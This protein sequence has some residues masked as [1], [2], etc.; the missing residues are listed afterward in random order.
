MSSPTTDTVQV[1]RSTAAFD[2]NMPEV[3]HL[4]GGEIV[5][6]RGARTLEVTDPA[7]GTPLTTIPLGTR[8]DV[9][10][11]VSAAHNAAPS[12][13][14]LIPRARSEHLHALADA[15]ERDAD[16]LRM[17]EALNCGKPAEVTQDD[18]GS[19]VDTLRFMAGAG[20]STITPAA[21]DYVPGTLSMII[22]EPL[23]VVGLITPWNYPLLMAVWK[24]APALMAGNTTVLKPSEVTPLTTL[25]LAQ[26]ATDVLP[27]GVL[28]VVLGDGATVG[29]ELAT[30]P[31]IQ[32]VALTGSIRAGVA[33][34]GAA[35]TTV[36]RVHL[37]LGGKAPVLVCDDAD[38]DLA[39]QTVADAGYWN[40][41]QECGA[42]CRVIA[43][44]SIADELSDKLVALVSRKNLAE[45][46]I[47][48]DNPLG[49]MIS[50]AHYQRVMTALNSAIEDG[51]QPLIGGHGDDTHG[52]WVE[53][54]VLRA[55]AGSAITRTEVFGPVVTIETFTG[56]DEGVRRA[57]DTQ[58]GL[59][60]SV[61][62]RDV[63]KALTL[64]RVLDFGSV[65]VNTHLALP[66]EMPWAGFKRSGYGRDLSGYA[67]DD[68]SR[69]KH[70]A[71]H[72][73]R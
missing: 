58:Y 14:A 6:V 54:T 20:R 7:R 21:G 13:S 72:H 17:L 47:D 50:H 40:A 31:G 57:N 15:I 44:A 52:F 9:A 59:T 61:F 66:T 34:A 69:T 3:G 64:G 53:P 39:A 25:R 22:R 46:Q 26:L 11:A 35:A 23:G 5:P 38:L 43:H 56:I 32:M 67:L 42:A 8:A 41:G 18:I 49:P 73:H 37:E 27:P 45:P 62:T 28:N 55:H 48:A 4:I 65:N 68:Y 36:K 63:N 12:W 10:D 1:H 33:V 71:I 60:G 16:H 24:I 70:L 30:H 29:A 2:V 19:A 51:A